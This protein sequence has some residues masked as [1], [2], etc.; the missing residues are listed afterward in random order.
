MKK[1]RIVSVILSICMLLA[2][3]MVPTTETKATETNDTILEAR[4][5]VLMIWWAVQDAGGNYQNVF[6]GTGFLIGTEDDAQYVVTNYH[7]AAPLEYMST[8]EQKAIWDYAG[9]SYDKELKSELHIVL[10]RDSYIKAEIIQYSRVADFA[11]LKM[12]KPIYGG[13]T[14]AVL[15]DSSTLKETTEVYALG[16]PGIM[17]YGQAD[18][19]YTYDDVTVTNGKITKLQEN[20]IVGDQSTPIPVI[21]HGASIA[22][23]NSGGPLMKNNGLVI[24]VN[25]NLVGSNTDTYYYSIQINEIRDVLDMEGIEYLTAS[26]SGSESADEPEQTDEP[27]ATEEPEQTEEPAPIEEPVEE[28]TVDP[29]L[30]E[31]LSKLISKAE[32]VDKAAYTEET[33]SILNDKI[34]AAKEVYNNTEATES[35]IQSAQSDLQKAVDGLVEAPAGFPIWIIG[36]IAAVVVIIIVAVI[37]AMNGKK[38]KAKEEEARRRAE[39]QRKASQK[40][41]GGQW[42]TPSQ[43]PVTPPAYNYSEGSEET[44][45]LNDGG[46]ETTVLNGQ[47]IPSACLIRKKNGEKVTISKAVF[48]IGKERRKVDYCISDNSNVSRSHADIVYR[49]GAFYIV[50]QN[51]TNGTTVNGGSVAAGQEKKLNNNDVVKLADEEFQF[52]MF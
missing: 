44:G 21:V 41:A 38:K 47:S 2:M 52:K 51:A 42:N 24:G 1:K 39:M 49:D 22:P 11:I 18:T 23:G 26:D 5:S 30:K 33:V 34:Q 4:N 17:D 16:F 25:S 8:D 40:P 43:K 15:G 45:V 10:K 50:D 35:E 46:S 14:P 29:S 48:K 6:S 3:L 28:P 19:T 31:E 7:V 32:D 27:A 36:V 20:Y 12:E 37:V 9:V 13:R